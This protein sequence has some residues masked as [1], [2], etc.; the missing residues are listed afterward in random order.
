MLAA[1][2]TGTSAPC[3]IGGGLLGLEAAYG[4]ARRGMAVTR[5]PPD[6]DA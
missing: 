6:A 1:A 4:L 3:V 5:A 2:E